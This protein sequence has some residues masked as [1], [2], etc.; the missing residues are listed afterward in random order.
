MKFFSVFF[1]IN[2]GNKNWENRA[3]FVL[4]LVV[5]GLFFWTVSKV[6]GEFFTRQPSGYYGL[7]TQGFIKGQVNAAITP[8]PELLA[9]KDPYDPVANAPYRVHDMTL[10]RGKYYLYFGVAPIVLFIHPIGIITGWFPTEICV[11]AFFCSVGIGFSL[12]LLKGLRDAYFPESPGWALGSGALVV[13]LAHP[14]ARLTL[15][16]NFYEV[17]IACAFAMHMAMFYTLFLALRTKGKNAAVMLV[18]SSVFYGLT[19]ASRPNYFLSGFTLVGPW[20][21]TIRKSAS[22]NLFKNTIIYTAAAFGPAVFIG[23]GLLSYNKLRFGSPAEFGMAYQLAGERVLASRILH[24][25]HFKFRFTEYLAGSMH[26]SRYFPFLYG[27]GD[28][29]AGVLIYSPWLWFMPLA[30]CFPQGSFVKGRLSALIIL[31]IGCGLNFFILCV[32]WWGLDRYVVDYEA[33]ALILA[34]VGVLALTGLFKKSRIVCFSIFI[35]GFFS[36]ASA[37][38]IYLK[39][40]PDPKLLNSIALIANAP[41]QQLEALYG[42]AYGG[43]K[44][45]LQ[46]PDGKKSQ[47]SS[48]PIFETGIAGDQRDWLQI[49]YQDDDHARLAFFHAGLGMFRGQIFKIPANRKIIVEVECGSLLPPSTHP[50]F[51][52]WSP[53]EYNALRRGLYVRVGGE[54]VLRAVLDCYDSTL[55]DLRIGRFNWPVGGVL[56][57]F[58]GSVIN[59]S[60]FPMRRPVFIQNGHAKREPLTLKLW[61][62]ADKIGRVEPLVSTGDKKLF[63][64]FICNYM[65][66]GRVAFSLYHHGDEPII[67]PEVN[68]DPLAPH[69]LQLWM[70]S[71]AD[72]AEITS[73]DGYKPKKNRLVLLFDGKTVIDR[74]QVFY[75]ADPATVIFGRNDF[76]TDLIAPR[77]SGS[78]EEV[79]GSSYDSLPKGDLLRDYGS[80]EMEVKFISARKGASEPLVVSGVKGAGDFLYMR[81]LEDNKVVF[82]FDHWGVG[83]IV[84][85]LVTLDLAKTHRLRLSMG[86]LYPV[87]TEVGVWRQKVYV[88]L[89]DTV[90]L[91]GTYATHPTTRTQIVIGENPLQGSSCGPKFSGVISQVVRIQKPAW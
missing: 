10:F 3:I 24:F 55:D 1:G 47:G 44:L 8:R 85:D 74:D 89:D 52:N 4:G 72:P 32:Y 12:A 75:P 76:I 33:S 21:L 30:F 77:F 51:K 31:G 58:S 88:M 42:V 25:D 63:D 2:N 59:V 43:I 56:A 71:L 11:V 48:E 7:Q 17:P 46:L 62:P 78:I 27:Y 40:F 53:D 15:L 68:F 39:R 49:D 66:M 60:T 26:F 34:S 41:V 83:G 54:T 36:I 91:S 65:G 28:K 57:E 18:L 70:G 90:V 80:I 79:R 13:A 69:V 61:L 19:I 87:D 20:I 67:G 14:A 64:M 9:L 45:E 86:S 81:Y 84:G 22:G 38:G 37:L 82:G 29:P 16:G 73:V 6:S 5:S 35:I 50:I 23:V